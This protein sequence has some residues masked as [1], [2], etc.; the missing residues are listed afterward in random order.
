M[1]A[2][3]GGAEGGVNIGRRCGSVSGK[4]WAKRSFEFNQGYAGAFG[5]AEAVERGEGRGGSYSTLCDRWRSTEVGES[6]TLEDAC[7][8]DTIDQRIR[9]DG[10]G[11]GVQCV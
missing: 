9:A 1:G 8:P 11:G 6:G 7:S 3:S 2:I 10:D 5:G 4:F